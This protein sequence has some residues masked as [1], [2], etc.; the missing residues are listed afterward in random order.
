MSSSKVSFCK[1]K[2]VVAKLSDEQFLPE[3][4]NVLGQ[5]PSCDQAAGPAVRPL[6]EVAPLEWRP[7]D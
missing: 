6:T 1:F 2:N 3:F 7:C 4:E 5:L